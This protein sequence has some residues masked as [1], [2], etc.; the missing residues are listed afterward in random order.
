MKEYDKKNIYIW[1]VII[2][3]KLLFSK[4]H[5]SHP[6]SKSKS[7][8]L[9]CKTKNIMKQ[10]SRSLLYGYITYYVEVWENITKKPTQK[11]YIHYRDL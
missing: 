2:N 11:I 8:I 5:T 9:L 7:I 10:N 1:G 6:K 4:P 3:R